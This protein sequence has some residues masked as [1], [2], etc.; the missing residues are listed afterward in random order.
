M[1]IHILIYFYS[2][3]ENLAKYCVMLLKSCSNSS[4]SNVS[5]ILLLQQLLYAKLMF[6][7]SSK[8]FI[9]RYA[10]DIMGR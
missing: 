8:D 3:K 2:S 4:I 10:I 5:L 1:N 7:F 6:M 9:S